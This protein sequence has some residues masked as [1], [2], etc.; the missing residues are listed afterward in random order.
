MSF[1]LEQLRREIVQIVSPVDPGVSTAAD[2]KLVLD[3][4]LFQ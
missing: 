2:M 4:V 1:L 3:A